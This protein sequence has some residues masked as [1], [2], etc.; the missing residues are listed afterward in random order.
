M[1]GLCVTPRTIVH[2]P[3]LSLLPAGWKATWKSSTLGG[4]ALGRRSSKRRDGG[5]D[6]HDA[7]IWAQGYLPRGSFCMKENKHRF[8]SCVSLMKYNWHIWWFL[9]LPV[10]SSNNPI[11]N[12]PLYSFYRRW[13][14]FRH[15]H[16]TRKGQKGIQ[17]QAFHS[18]QLILSKILPRYFNGKGGTILYFPITSYIIKA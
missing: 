2:L 18:M 1:K 12:V 7:A 11:V 14:W 15:C 9:L 13:A 8:F 16:T 5:L 6:A 17:T 10:V 3:S 4:I